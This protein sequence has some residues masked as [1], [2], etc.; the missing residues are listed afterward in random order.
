[1][2]IG[3]YIVEIFYIYDYDVSNEG[4]IRMVYKVLERLNQ[5][6]MF[7]RMICVE[8][9]LISFILKLN[10]LSFKDRKFRLCQIVI[11]KNKE[12]KIQSD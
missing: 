8:Y 7:F 12:I 10:E 1:M 2:R 9:F 3:I 5:N 4:K 11:K 6:D